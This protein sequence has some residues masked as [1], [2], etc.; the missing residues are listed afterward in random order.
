M[1]DVSSSLTQHKP[2]LTGLRCQIPAGPGNMAPK[3]PRHQDAGAYQSF[4]Q[5]HEAVAVQ[6]QI[7]HIGYTYDA[8][9][10]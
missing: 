6:L 7:M 5:Q 1:T 10:Y 8:L 9:A 2:D 4:E 3:D